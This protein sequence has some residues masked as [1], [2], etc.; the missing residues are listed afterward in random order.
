[1]FG[2]EIWSSFSHIANY[3]SVHVVNKHVKPSLIE[4][5]ITKKQQ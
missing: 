3:L 1:M 2:I 4:N 5:R